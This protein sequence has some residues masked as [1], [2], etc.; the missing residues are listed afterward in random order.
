MKILSIEPTPS[1]NTM[2]VIVDEALAGGTS[3]NYKKDDAEKA[4]DKI[5]KLLQIDGVKGI[6]HVADFLAVERHPKADWEAVLPEVR[7]VFGEENTSDH[8]EEKP[9]DHFGEVQVQVLQ[10]KSIPLQIKLLTGDEEKRYGLPDYFANAMSEAQLDGDNV[11][12]QRKWKDFGIRYGDLDKI[13]QEVTDEI[14]ASYPS[15]RVQAIVEAAREAGDHPVQSRDLKKVSAEMLKS[16]DTWQERYQ[17]LEQ[18]P[19]PEVNDIP[20]L[21]VALEDEKVSVRRLAVVYL[22]MIED[23]SVLPSLYKGLHDKN[24]S[25]RRTAGDCL[26]DL[27]FPAAEEEMMKALADKNKLV[28]WRAAMFLYEAGTEK[29]LEALKAAEEDPEFEVKLQIKMAIERIAEG[30]EAKGSVWKQMT[31]ARKQRMEE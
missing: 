28:R 26:S 20:M 6:Y 29:S 4:P 16:C 11:V 5:K 18:I 31:E 9:D 24:A 10:F 25:V 17:L 27:G 1:P 7:S 12:L 21:N 15:S 3:N 19:E 30:Q 14:L 13:A 2:K 23:E 22:G 8:T